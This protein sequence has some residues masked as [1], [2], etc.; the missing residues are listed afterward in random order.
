[1]VLRTDA[2]ETLSIPP[3]GPGACTGHCLQGW[4]ALSS[5]EVEDR[6]SLLQTALWGPGRTGDQ[7]EGGTR[8]LKEVWGKGVDRQHYGRDG[9]MEGQ[10]K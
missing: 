7:S 1:M 6:S 9:K 4:P 10:K 5:R 3:S 8:E 2:W